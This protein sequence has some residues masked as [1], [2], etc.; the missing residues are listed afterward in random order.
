MQGEPASD[1]TRPTAS[2]RA[3]P[4][5]VPDARHWAALSGVII[6][7]LTVIE[8]L[9]RITMG[10]RPALDDDAGLIDFMERTNR[11]SLVVVL[12]DCVLMTTLVLYLACLRRI[13]SEG[14]PDVS[15]LADLVFG[16]GL[17]FV[18]VTLVGDSM[19]AGI[20]LDAVGGGSDPSVMRALTEGHILM[21]GSAGSLLTILLV[22]IAAR[23]IRITG[24]L[25]P[26]T[27]NF[28]HVVAALNLLAEPTLFASTNSGSLLA[29]G[30]A[31]VAF[32]AVFPFLLWFTA[33]GITA[34]RMGTAT[35][36]VAEPA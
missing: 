5:E 30:G 6:A 3:R 17:V 33:V 22:E 29:P 2:N 18:A 12:I 10:I 27:A 13:L 32:F 21:F 23:I 35:E 19:E 36:P 16:T 24:V 8:A 9:V 25:P 1:N 15:W 34:Q 4:I 31:G 26:W 28:A 7:G 20:A 11:S 14:R